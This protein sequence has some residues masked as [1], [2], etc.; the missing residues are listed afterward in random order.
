MNSSFCWF[1]Q[2]Y[3][4]CLLL[5]KIVTFLY[6]STDLNQRNQSHDFMKKIFYFQVISINICDFDLSFSHLTNQQLVCNTC[7]YHDSLQSLFGTCG[8]LLLM[9]CMSAWLL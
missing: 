3:T 4:A 5:C 7:S 8:C 6:Q 9:L 1:K 2:S